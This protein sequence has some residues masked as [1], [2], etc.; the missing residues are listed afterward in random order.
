MK[1]IISLSLF[2]VLLLACNNNSDDN[3]DYTEEYETTTLKNVGDNAPNFNITSLEGENFNTDSLKGK[4]IFLNFFT[5]SCP[6]C[7]LE[8]PQLEKE[9]WQKYKSRDDIVILS[10]GRE[11]SN[12][13][14]NKFYH[15]KGFSF[16]MAADTN[17]FI[18]SLFAEKFVP[19]NI[20]IDKTGKI[21]FTKV[22]YN[23]KEGLTEIIEVLKKE[24]AN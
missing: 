6:M 17:R 2:F 21:I 22:G 20:I 4:T 3:E 5:L 16:P 13:E 10:I 11:H 9:I 18:Y 19:R 1:K 7:M 15:K 24:F 8:L 12:N 23:K 14:L